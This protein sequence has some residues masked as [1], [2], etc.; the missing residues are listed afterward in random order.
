MGANPAVRE[1]LAGAAG[2]VAAGGV[3]GRERVARA[4]LGGDRGG[5]GPH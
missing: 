1:E 3:E 2:A 5:D 4:A